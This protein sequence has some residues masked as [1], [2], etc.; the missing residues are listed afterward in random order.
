MTINV[1]TL[2]EAQRLAGLEFSTEQRR[3]ALGAFEGYLAGYES[4]RAAGLANGEAP[5]LRFDARL[6]G[7]TY[8][9]GDGR[10]VRG[11]A[12]AP[13]LPRDEEAIAYAPVAWL[14]SWIERR[15]LSSERLTSI[16]LRRLKRYDRNL[17]CVVTLLEESALAAARRADGEIAAG[18]YRGPLHGIPW[19]AK[20]LLDTAGI[21]TTWGAAPFRDRVP[22]RDAAVVRRLE[23]AGAVLIAK[24]TL[25]A[26]ANGDVWFGGRTRNPWNRRHGSSGSS[27]GSASAV[28][29]G[30]VGFAIGSETLGSIVSPSTTCGTVGLRPTFGRVSRAGAMALSWSMDKLGPIT[31]TVEDAAL[32]L[33]AIAGPDA[34]DEPTP[35]ASVLDLPL[36]YNG[37]RRSVRGMRV[38]YRVP[39]FRAQRVDTTQRRAIRALRGAGVEVVPIETPSTNADALTPILWVE[40]A[41]AFDDLT[42]SGGVAEL[43]RQGDEAWPN[44]F[45]RARFVPAVELVQ[46]DRLRRRAMHELH[47]LFEARDLDAVIS[48]SRPPAPGDPFLRLTNFT[49]HPSLSLRS[50]IDRKRLP[51]GVTL[52]GRLFGEDA[53]LRLGRSLERTLDVWHLRPP[54]PPI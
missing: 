43:T 33:D 46:A 8:D 35:D 25:G 7:V 24:L 18:R 49:G 15:Q 50:G 47:D 44:I 42:R 17:H 6:P 39:S 54:L 5:A 22:D 1:R 16:Y 9:T 45:R 11:P 40:A 32:V 20:D 48:A 3:Q 23:Q 4:V 31:R 19:G 29:A 52:W 51:T 2:G 38:G 36:S 41:A 21:A 37:R 14:S 53:L 27:A 28:A 26:L 30:L 13:R 34:E 12:G 10:F